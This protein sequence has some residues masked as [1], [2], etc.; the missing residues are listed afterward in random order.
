MNRTL[1]PQTQPWMTE[2]ET[3]AVFSAIAA[4]GGEARF[5]GGAVRNA[6]LG[7]AVTDI[8][9]ATTLIP[10]QTI[11]AMK[12]AGIGVA[13]TG[14]EHGTITAIASGKPF[15]VT[16]LRRDVSTDGRRATVA[17]TTDWNADGRL[18]DPTGGVEDLIAGRVRFVGDAHARIREDYLRILRFFRFHAWYG[19]G[20]LDEAAIA[21]AENNRL[22]LKKLSGE[23]IQ[24]ELLRLLEATNPMP[25]LRVMQEHRLLEEV[26]PAP[27]RLD[28]LSDLIA[29]AGAHSEPRSPVLSLACLLSK[30]EQ[31]RSVASSLKFS[32]VDRARLVQALSEEEGIAPGLSSPEIRRLLYRLGQEH[33]VDILLIRWAGNPDAGG[34]EALLHEARKWEKPEFPV[35]GR[36]AMDAGVTEGPGVGRI[37]AA[38]ERWWVAEDFLPGREVLLAKLKEFAAR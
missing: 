4:A 31:A 14:I 28:R 20:E 16:S 29:I 21:A 25:A 17:F 35:D 5:V 11:A 1:D 27:L 7:L 32:N 13:P 24:K 18:Y 8:D 12:S 9:I 23:R 19:K 22:G 3:L 2:R 15:E 30:K 38:V 33:F 34:W 6:L 26:L 36:D 10:E 37:L